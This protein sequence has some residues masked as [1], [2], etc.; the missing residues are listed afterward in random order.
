MPNVGGFEIS[1]KIKQISGTSPII[2]ISAEDNIDVIL[3]AYN[4]GCQDYIKKPFHVK[5]LLAKVSLIMQ[6]KPSTKVKL[7]EKCFY[8]TKSKV[9]TFNETIIP[10]TQKETSML[11][12]LVVNLGMTVPHE[13]AEKFI[14]GDHIGNGYV[15]Q[16]ISKLRKKIPCVQIYNH[17]GNGYRLEIDE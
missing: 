15:R 9:L 5:E 7:S 11:H 12:L 13:D 10:L 14:W 3:K 4:L 2:V 16:L 1:K 17:S 8:D 6:S